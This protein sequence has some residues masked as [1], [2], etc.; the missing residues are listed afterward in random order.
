MIVLRLDNLYCMECYR[1]SGPAEIRRP[2][3]WLVYDPSPETSRTG[4]IEGAC[5]IHVEYLSGLGAI[6][7]EWRG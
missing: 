7:R 1:N 2:A 6:E 3:L 5:E 4:I